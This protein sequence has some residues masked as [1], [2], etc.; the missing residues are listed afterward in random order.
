M[1]AKGQFKVLGRPVG[2]DAPCFVIAEAGI[3]HNGKLALALELVDAAAAAG[4]DAVKFQTFKSDK[5]V[6]P[7]ADK[8]EY[9]MLTTG[10]QESQLDM[11]RKL[12]LSFDDF[13]TI[14]RHCRD[15]GIL[16]LSTPFDDD[17]IG[18]LND[19]DMPLF[20]VPSG[21][22]TNFPYLARIAATGRPVIMSTGM[23]TLGEVD[24]ALRVLHQGGCDHIAILHC[25]SNY[26]AAF[27]D[28]NLRA[29]DTLRAA[30]GLPV[31]YSD[32]TLG[33]EVAL[34]AV[35]RE[36]CILEKHF[37]LDK[38][39]VGPDHTA[40][41]DPSELAALIRGVR[42]IES[43]LGHGRKEPCAAEVNTAQVARRSLFLG[44][45]MAEEEE[46]TLPDLIALR[47]AGGISPAQSR[48]VIGRRTRRPL[49]AGTR[50]EWEDIQ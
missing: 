27:E 15:R 36:A 9:Q 35:A 49:A 2:C 23:A 31:G 34:A 42:L 19:L 12:E 38:T 44:R 7:I 17:S 32:H 20:K 46:I 24:E 14:S 21:E 26:P 29:M 50:L 8:A 45:D 5:V 11:V 18:F 1:I 40:S 47:P 10:E 22:I 37:T 30:F 4:A 33:I 6:S 28:S 41:L 13:R 16:F 39:M 3:N 48:M 25:V 43:A